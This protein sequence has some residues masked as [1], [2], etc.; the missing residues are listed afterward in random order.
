MAEE[1]RCYAC[2][3]M[4]PVEDFYRNALCRDGRRNI[5]KSCSGERAKAW[6]K[7][8]P[9][10]IAEHD[11]R[12]ERKHPEAVAARTAR[13]RAAHPEKYKAR[14]DLNNAVLLGKIRK[15]AKCD[16]CGSEPESSRHIQAHHD[17]YAKP[18]EVEWLCK[19]CHLS[20][21]GQRDRD[22]EALAPFDSEEKT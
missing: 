3:G 10:R 13:M 8:N 11:K 18:L 17:D 12:Y 15:P 2:E 19:A 9:G 7:A 4:K 6:R 16:R 14:S 5:C 22:A 20:E 21:H 1:K